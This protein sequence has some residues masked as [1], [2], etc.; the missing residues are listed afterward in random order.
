MYEQMS[1]LK[2]ENVDDPRYI[3]ITD[4]RNDGVLK[5]DTFKSLPDEKA[6]D[7]ILKE[8]DILFARSEQP[9]VRLFNLKIFRLACFAGY[10]IKASP[11]PDLLLSD[12]LYFSQNQGIYEDW[13]TVYL[14]KL[15]FKI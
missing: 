8:G 12:Y 5:N 3:R 2:E 7:Y 13:K 10:L 11:N 1:Q 14:I 6:K 15:L 4:F 9:L